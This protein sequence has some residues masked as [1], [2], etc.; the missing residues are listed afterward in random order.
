MGRHWTKDEDALLQEK[1][2]DA[3]IAELERLFGRPMTHISQRAFKLKIKRIHK[4]DMK[5]L[6]HV[7]LA[8]RWSKSRAPRPSKPIKPSKSLLD[9]HG[10]YIRLWEV[11]V[12]TDPE[13]RCL[14]LQY[15]RILFPHRTPDEIIAMQI[16]LGVW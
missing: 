12:L 9:L 1:Y 14:P 13:I 8:K 11:R 7:G 16:E 10:R 5:A 15:I 4:Q 3:D 2:P 6:S